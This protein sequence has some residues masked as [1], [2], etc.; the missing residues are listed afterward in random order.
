ME[1][2]WLR[3]NQMMILPFSTAPACANYSVVFEVEIEKRDD[4]EKK[5]QYYTTTRTRS[6][7]LV[8]GP[9]GLFLSLTFNACW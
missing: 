3:D 8:V 6:Y 1:S 9:L 4:E 7:S 5:D 2:K